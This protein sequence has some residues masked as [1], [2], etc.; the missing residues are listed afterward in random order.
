MTRKVKNPGRGY[1]GH[2]KV[3][4]YHY[5]NNGKFI[6][7]FNC[8]SDLRKEY[9]FKDTGKR[10][11]FNNKKWKLFNYDVLPDNTYY[12]NYR[13]GR[14]KLLKLEKIANSL[15]CVNNCTDNIPVKMYNLLN[16]EIAT[17]KNAY[18]ASLAT[19]VAQSTVYY[20][21]N[22]GK[23]M[24]KGEFYFKYANQTQQV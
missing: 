7:E 18:I 11:L 22:K 12:S 2:E 16:E 1:A 21:C 17:F 23:G 13:I 19:N 14:E 9:F 20:D 10:P 6:K 4:L 15:Y 24:P 5:D 3:K 8:V